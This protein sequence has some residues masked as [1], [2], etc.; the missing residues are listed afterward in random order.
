MSNPNGTPE[1]LV[2][3]H[4][5]NQNR[6]VHGILSA[7]ADDLAPEAARIADAIMELPYIVAADRIGAERIGMLLV[8]VGRIERALADERVE[9]RRGAPRNLMKITG[10]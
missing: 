7:S 5:G 2:A 9:G 6:L 1:T 4:P 10:G 8:Q 3:A